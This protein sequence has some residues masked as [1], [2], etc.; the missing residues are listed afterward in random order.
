VT[1][2]PKEVLAYLESVG[3][4]RGDVKGLRTDS[5]HAFDVFAAVAR[6]LAEDRKAENRLVK[7]MAAWIK[8]ERESLGEVEDPAE[9]IDRLQAERDGVNERIVAIKEFN[10]TCASA[11]EVA[12]DAQSEVEQQKAEVARLNDRVQSLKK[13]LSEAEYDHGKAVR[14]LDSRNSDAEA[15]A[16]AAKN[17]NPEDSGEVEAERDGIDR[18]IADLKEARGAYQERLKR[19][20]QIGAKESELAEKQARA[21]ALDAGVKLFQKRAP[22]EALAR[23]KMPVEGLEYK[24]GKFYVNGTH[25]DQL[26]GAETLDIAA[27]FTI[28]KVRQKGL[29]VV[30]VDGLEKLG[31]EQRTAFFEL[32]RDAGIQLWAAEV[33]HGQG[34]PDGE[35]VLYVVMAGGEPAEVKTT[36]AEAEEEPNQAGLKF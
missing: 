11:E 18:R 9:E 12:R 1:T 8:T 2:D 6:M 10:K 20:G 24:D 16:K 36:V 25:I 23:T 7:E 33:D 28:E 21:K 32:M 31:E 30:C 22:A 4:S 35:G 17:L 15:A 13:Q 3:L 14:K 29:H 26:S 34:A 19:E 27:R 5:T